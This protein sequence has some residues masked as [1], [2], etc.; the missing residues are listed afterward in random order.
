MSV[1]GSADGSLAAIDARTSSAPDKTGVGSFTG[2]AND[3]SPAANGT[4]AVA[5]ASP[6]PTSSE[7]VPPLI[8]ARPASPAGTSPAI[9]MVEI[10][11]DPAAATGTAFILNRQSG[12]SCDRADIARV[13]AS[14][15][16]DIGGVAAV[17]A[18]VTSAS[19]ADR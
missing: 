18:A 3:R 6:A 15:D 19:V 4:R 2:T 8:H 13:A 10:C 12:L 11:L 7:M 16:E 17:L 5:V 9:Q 1:K 14:F